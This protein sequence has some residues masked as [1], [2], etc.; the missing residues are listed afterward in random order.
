[1]DDLATKADCKGLQEKRLK[2]QESLEKSDFR[3]VK[4]TRSETHK[5]R[6]EIMEELGLKK[7]Q[8]AQDKQKWGKKSDHG[9]QRQPRNKVQAKK[10]K[11]F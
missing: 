1:M 8:D 2:W 7:I 11:K 9:H 6:N 4:K 10:W 3:N 5:K